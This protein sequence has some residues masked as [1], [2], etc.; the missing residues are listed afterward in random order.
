MLSLS[1]PSAQTANSPGGGMLSWPSPSSCWPEQRAGTGGDRDISSSYRHPHSCH[2]S[3]MYRP[4]ST[5]LFTPPCSCS[6]RKQ[7][8]ANGP[9]EQVQAPALQLCRQ[10]CLALLHQ[11]GKNKRGRR[12]LGEEMAGSSGKACLKGIGWK[13]RVRNDKKR[14][15]VVPQTGWLLTPLVPAP[16]VL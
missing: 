14:K 13:L 12:K 2:C 7:T 11:V 9:Q 1:S 5:A 6:K 15:R 10:H 3:Q 4:A 16:V 8:H